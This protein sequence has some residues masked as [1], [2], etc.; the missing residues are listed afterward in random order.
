MSHETPLTT[1]D[2]NRSIQVR[3]ADVCLVRMDMLGNIPIQ[4]THTQHLDTLKQIGEI[5]ESPLI[6]T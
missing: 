3:R 6:C 4:H 1:H 5:H 2:V